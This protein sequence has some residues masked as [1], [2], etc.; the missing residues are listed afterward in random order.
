MRRLF[1][2]RNENGFTLI[3]V[4][5]ALSLLLVLAI[6]AGAFAVN[7]LRLSAQQQRMQ[8]AVTV[9]SERMELVQRL[10]ASNT[11]AQT[12]TAG[13]DATAVTNAWAANA[14]V[15]GVAQT[16]PLTSAGAV[17]TIPL[18]ATTDRSG[19]T[20]TST[21][22]IGSCYQPKAGGACGKVGTKTEAQANADT[23]YS[24]MVRVIVT[25]TYTGTCAGVSPCRYTTSALFDTTPDQTWQT[26]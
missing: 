11:Q 6:A 9:A 5:V 19:T 17:E 20:Y 23:A 16:Y 8:V 7:A 25:V 14:S 24:R 18:T 12:L 13:R 4:V 21:V 15:E 22:L 10:T 1:S 26:K 3:E 2:T